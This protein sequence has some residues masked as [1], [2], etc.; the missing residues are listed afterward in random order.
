MTHTHTF[1]FRQRQIIMRSAE[2]HDGN[3]QKVFLKQED[4]RNGIRIKDP[5][6]INILFRDPILRDEIVETM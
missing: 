6:R 4:I 5:H 2:E 3:L 1:F